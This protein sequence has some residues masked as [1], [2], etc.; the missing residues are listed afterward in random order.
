MSFETVIMNH[1]PPA[2]LKQNGLIETEVTVKQEPAAVETECPPAVANGCHGN[3]TANG[4]KNNVPVENSY[5]AIPTTELF[6][7]GERT[8]VG[9]KPLSTIE[10][11][12][13]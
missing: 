3:L 11:I 6:A 5:K 8:I 2:F 4:L 7:L 9:E 1:P 10:R 12:H 13:G